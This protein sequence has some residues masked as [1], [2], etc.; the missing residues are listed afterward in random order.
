[1]SGWGIRLVSEMLRQLWRHVDHQQ[2]KGFNSQWYLR[3]GS[4]PRQALLSPDPTVLTPLYP[5]ADRFWADPFLWHR[6]GQWWIF[7]EE[8]IFGQSHAHIS[9][10]EIDEHGHPLGPM[11]PVVQEPFHLSYPFL[12]EFEGTLWMLPEMSGNQSI[13]VY[14]CM[15]FPFK[16]KRET[17]LMSSL[18]AGDPT[19]MEHEGRWYLFLT[20]MKH[21]YRLND[22]LF[23]FHSSHPFGHEW[24]ALQTGHPQIHDL[25]SARPAGRL[26]TVDG[27]LY[28]PSQGSWRRYG[29]QLN[30]N[31]VETLA[32]TAY[33][34]QRHAMV[35]ADCIPGNRGLHHIDWC[36]GLL[37]M[38][39]QRFIPRRPPS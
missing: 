33:R 11:R 36:K 28:R 1:M 8:W 5:P 24:K 31:K 15:D 6:N 25:G 35:S 27:Q 13:H 32:P 19:L 34:E 16:W 22:S 17:C 21:P 38:D 14:R 37:V 9:V 10:M 4:T 18:Q 7:V 29:Y 23:V 20:L 2:E 30:I 3:I 39:A 26:F 12:F